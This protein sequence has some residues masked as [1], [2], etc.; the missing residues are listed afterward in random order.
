MKTKHAN[1]MV[2]AVMAATLLLAL[3]PA[4]ALAAAED[5]VGTAALFDVGMGARALGMGGAF[6]AVA[7]D[8]N[9]LYYNPAG[10]ALIEDHDVT[11][12]YS[13]LFGAGNYFG[14]G[15]AQKNIGAAV[16][17]LLST[18]T[19]TDEYGNPTEEFGYREGTLA[20]GYAHAFGPFALGGAVKLYAQDASA[21]RGFGATGDI[22]ALITLPYL[23]G[24]RFGAV[25]RNLIGAVKFQSGH[26]DNFDQSYVLGL[27]V[28]PLKGFM[29]AADYDITHS[30]G[31]VGVEY[32]IID[33]FAARAGAT[34]DADKQWGFTAGAGFA[35]AG[36]RV[37]YAYQFHTELPDSHWVSL[38]YSF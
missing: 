18:A 29:V 14:A 32:Q 17:G 20:G 2:I 6:V 22:G 23:D 24:I 36:F 12:M 19:G 21:N 34:M 37:D 5:P 33:A 13:A 27:S 8:A 31:R 15:Y 26:T 7:D 38:G 4:A 9:A 35:L 28:R 10:L 30:I 16:F 25:A 11:S 3:A 1:W